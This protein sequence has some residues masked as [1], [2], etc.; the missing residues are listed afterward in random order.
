MGGLLGNPLGFK[1]RLYAS[2]NL[3][4][5]TDGIYSYINAN[6]PENKYG[7]E[8]NTLLIQITTNGREDCWQIAFC[9]N[10]RKVGIRLRTVNVWGD[11]KDIVTSLL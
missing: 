3:N 6:D 1:R 2:D 4:N 10:A 9:A 8:S 5:I 7:T 11:W